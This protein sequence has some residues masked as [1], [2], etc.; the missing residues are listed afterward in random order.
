MLKFYSN[1]DVI[2]SIMLT[3][4]SGTILRYLFYY[5][6]N[7]IIIIFNL[8]L[9]TK[10]PDNIWTVLQQKAMHIISIQLVI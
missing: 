10:K 8:L 3:C 1:N 2:V 6:I 7:I 4:H 9:L 5:S